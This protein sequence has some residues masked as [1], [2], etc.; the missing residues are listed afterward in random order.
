M[1]SEE[2]GELAERAGAAAKLYGKAQRWALAALAGNCLWLVSCFASAG[3]H[4][5]ILWGAQASGIVGI[6][7]M[8]RSTW[9]SWRAGKVWRPTP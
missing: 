2:W 8:W 3:V 5:A 6:L 9:C 4:P 1:T 7:C